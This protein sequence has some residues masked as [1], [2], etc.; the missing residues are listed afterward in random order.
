MGAGG[1]HLYCP[2]QLWS[3]GAPLTPHASPWQSATKFATVLAE[4]ATSIGSAAV[5]LLPDP[6]LLALLDPRGGAR[7][8][9][10]AAADPE[11]APRFTAVLTSWCNAVESLLTEG[12]QDA[13]GAEDA[14]PELELE[15][16]RRRMTTLNGIAEQLAS[17]NVRTIVAVAA[18][19]KAPAAV[20]W[21]DME[22]QLADAASES[23]ETV[24]YLSTL[25][26]SL[27]CLYTSGSWSSLE[28]GHVL[29]ACLSDAIMLTPF[30][31]LP[32][33]PLRLLLPLESPAAIIEALPL[34]ANNLR[35]VHGISR[36][37]SQPA[38]LA[39]FL[40]R[41]ANQLI[42]R[43]REHLL[44]PGKLWE[45]DKLVLVENLQAAVRLHAAFVEQC[46]ALLRG[47]AAGTSLPAKPSIAQQQQQHSP[48]PTTAL[49]SADADSAFAKY[50]LFARRCRKLVDLFSTVHQFAAL[51]THSHVEGVNAVLARFGELAEDMKRRP[52]DLLD[53]NRNQVRNPVHGM[54]ARHKG[55]L[56]AQRIENKWLS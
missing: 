42:R 10:R 20:R 47:G 32:R 6:A 26:G 40:H 17:T 46:G 14:G 52:Y 37:Y 22:L 3:E 4:A 41:I 16:W 13:K 27:E 2:T 54:C 39:A 19:A 9:S 55:I 51:T 1:R 24:K 36:H 45:Q 5:L 35:M 48:L 25:E 23:R 33:P 11:L 49:S 28:K 34:V 56:R 38:A 29:I 12:L 15:F 50:G 30:T 43:S 8:A 53:W 7:A 31:T 18:A 21:H 44:V